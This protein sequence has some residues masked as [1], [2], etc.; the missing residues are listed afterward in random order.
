MVDL[1]L[2]SCYP[3]FIIQ[4]RGNSVCNLYVISVKNRELCFEH[5]FTYRP[6]PIE[7]TPC[8]VICEVGMYSGDGLYLSRRVHIE[9]ETL[10]GYRVWF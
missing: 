10:S 5:Y 2:L 3:S 7:N 1:C 9:N 8:N 4:K 6:D